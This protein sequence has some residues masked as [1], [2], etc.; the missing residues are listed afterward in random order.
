MKVTSLKGAVLATSIYSGGSQIGVNVTISLPEV[1]P[2]TT[3]VTAAGGTLELPV[4]TKL[5]AMEASLTKQG[6]DSEWLKALKP[7]PMDIIANIV[8][9]SVAPDGTSTPQH[10]KAYLRA[11]PKTM[12]AIEATYGE[13]IEGEIT[14][15]VLSYKLTSDGSTFLH[16]DPVKGIYK[17]N[18]KDYA[19]KVKAMI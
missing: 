13:A 16:I 14:F 4:L 9:Q 3:E 2:S 7:E 5:D 15:S 6:I 12:P 1:T 11:V 19:A 8:Q 18:G 17:V 10:I